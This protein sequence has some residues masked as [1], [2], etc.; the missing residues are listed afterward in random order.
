MTDTETL[1]AEINFL[2]RSLIDGSSE[3]ATDCWFENMQAVSNLA[4]SMNYQCKFGSGT[5][6]IPVLMTPRLK[7][8]RPT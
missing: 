1:K 4:N 6:K 8:V 7:A 2:R 5:G 3:I